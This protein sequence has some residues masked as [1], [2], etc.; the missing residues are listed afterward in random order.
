LELEVDGQVVDDVGGESYRATDLKPA[1]SYEMRV[2]F[3]NS[4]GASDWSD[5]AFLW[6]NPTVPDQPDLPACSESLSS[7]SML[8]VVPGEVTSNGKDIDDWEFE[9]RPTAERL[10]DYAARANISAA[11]LT[12]PCGGLLFDSLPSELATPPPACDGAALLTDGVATPAAEYEV[13]A[14]AIN[15]LGASPWSEV[16]ICSTAPEPVEPFPLIYLIVGLGGAVLC[17]VCAMVAVW[18]TNLRKVIAPKLRRKKPNDEPLKTF[19]TQ[20]AVP[21]EEEDPELVINPI[22]LA[23]HHMEEDHKRAKDKKAAKRKGG[24]GRTGGLKRLWG[25]ESVSGTTAA[26]TSQPMNGKA[27]VDGWLADERARETAVNGVVQPQEPSP[28]GKGK[29]KGKGKAG[30]SKTKP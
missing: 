21:N 11:D 10:L 1:T 17:L 29:G 27:I 24:Q 30:S 3:S 13:R 26:S 7:P 4:I 2:R 6:T 14:R 5:V 19:V 16:V 20:E 8:A 25:N 9:T 23:R 15:A 22:M 28:A 12:N 18:K